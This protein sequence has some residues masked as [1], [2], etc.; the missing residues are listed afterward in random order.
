MPDHIAAVHVRVQR[1]YVHRNASHHRLIRESSLYPWCSA[2]WFERRASASLRQTIIK[3]G[4]ERLKAPD[5]FEVV[6]LAERG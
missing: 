5:D 3:F 6:W 2:G 4:V 1:F